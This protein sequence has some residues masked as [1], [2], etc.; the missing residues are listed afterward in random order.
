MST[1]EEMPICHK[2]PTSS[3]LFLTAFGI[4]FRFLKLKMNIYRTASDIRLIVFGEI[5]QR[6]LHLIPWVAQ[7]RAFLHDIH[8]ADLV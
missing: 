8:I 3:I 4:S 1:A 7:A 5:V 6:S 2:T